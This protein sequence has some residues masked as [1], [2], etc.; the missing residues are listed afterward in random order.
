[1]SIRVHEERPVSVATSDGVW[2][3]N[4]VSL[5]GIL[6]Q[7]LVKSATSSTM[8]DFSLTSD[9]NDVIYNRTDVTGIINEENELPLHGVYTMKISGATRNED[10]TI[11]LSVREI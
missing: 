2:Q 3:G 7:I 1:M 11:L 4:T 10:F 6:K 9:Q 5:N 8:L